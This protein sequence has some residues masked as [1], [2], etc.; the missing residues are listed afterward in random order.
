MGGSEGGERKERG[1]G[2]DDVHDVVLHILV[3][4]SLMR[5]RGD[6]CLKRKE[7]LEDLTTHALSSLSS[8][9]PPRYR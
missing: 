1:K 2:D 6:A 5:A 7:V 3:D 4:A 9:P 8:L